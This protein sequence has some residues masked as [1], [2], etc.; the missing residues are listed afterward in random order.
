VHYQHFFY[1]I[2]VHQPIPGITIGAPFQTLFGTIYTKGQWAVPLFWVISGV[3]FSHVY[4][5]GRT[6]TTRS[7]VVN[8]FAR[9]YPVHLVTL[10]V[11]TILQGIALARFGTTFI[12]PNYD[13]GHFLLQLGMASKWGFDNG[14]SFNAPIWSVSAE[15][16]IYALF[17]L[18]R[19]Y[20]GRVGGIVTFGLVVLFFWAFSTFPERSVLQCG[21][22]FFIGVMVCRFYEAFG[23][24]PL[25]LALCIAAALAVRLAV[26]NP[27][28]ALVGIC[29]S[30]AALVLATI[31]VERWVPRAL[32][33]AL[34]LLG[35]LTYSV[36]LWHF[37]IQVALFLLIV[38]GMGLS[39]P[40]LAVHPIFLIGYVSISVGVAYASFV[41]IER[42][43]RRWLRRFGSAPRDTNSS[44][45]HAQ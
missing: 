39:L 43:S 40:S 24:R 27:D 37:P 32:H 30:I 19:D 29:S 31:G 1:P 18:L 42:P 41:F 15:V 36:Y 34:A 26:S 10:L 38:G 45:F 22:F 16:L 23:D 14:H 3:V 6:G 12:V 8:R 5:P 4:P 7:F 44:N 28:W 20:L 2:G 25:L 11:I 17:W 35:N 9:L 33:G 21:L 13:I